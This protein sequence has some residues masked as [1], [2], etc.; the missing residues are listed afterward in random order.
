MSLILRSDNNLPASL[1]SKSSNLVGKSGDCYS[2]KTSIV[3]INSF[4]KFLSPDLLSYAERKKIEM[5]CCLFGKDGNLLAKKIFVFTILIPK[6]SNYIENSKFSDFT[7]KKSLQRQVC[8]IDNYF[9]PF[10]L[11]DIES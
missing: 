8:R 11:K 4:Y 1:P 9:R 6:A 5:L 2:I 10:I 3:K 7:Y